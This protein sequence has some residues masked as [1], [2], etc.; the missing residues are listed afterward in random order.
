MFISF[1]GNLNVF[2]KYMWGQILNTFIVKLPISHYLIRLQRCLA[3][4]YYQILPS[5]QLSVLLS[6]H[7]P[8]WGHPKKSTT[9]SCNWYC[10]PLGGGFDTDLPM[11]SNLNVDDIFWTQECKGCNILQ[12]FGIESL[13]HSAIVGGKQLRIIIHKSFE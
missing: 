2:C 9:H 11:Q 5:V 7:I 13:T 6:L 8:I 3:R 10:P 1:F 4:I 12:T